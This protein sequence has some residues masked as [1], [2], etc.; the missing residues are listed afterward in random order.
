MQ[1]DSRTFFHDGGNNGNDGFLLRRA[2]PI[3]TGTVFHDFDFNFTPDFG[4]STVQ[5]LDAYV[6][7]RYNSGLAIAGRQIQIAGRAW[8]SCRPDRVHF[9]Q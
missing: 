5:I 7:Y 3:F 6:N 1:V 2:R 4:G 9:V 8:S